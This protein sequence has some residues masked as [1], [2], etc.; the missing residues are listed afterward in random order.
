[1]V[2]VGDVQVT[3]P[4][5]ELEPQ[6][7]AIDV[8]GVAR[9]RR[10]GLARRV[11]GVASAVGEGHPATGAAAPLEHTAVRDAGVGTLASAVEGQALGAGD[12]TW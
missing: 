8:L 11:V 1:V 5:V 4:D 3:G 12:T 10:R 7:A 2:G 9:T 6:E